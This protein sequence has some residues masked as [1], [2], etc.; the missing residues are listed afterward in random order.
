MFP[1]YSS[2]Q[3][4]KHRFSSAY[5]KVAAIIALITFPMMMGVW[6]LANP[7]ITVVFGA[8]WQPVVLLLMILAPVGMIQS[9][10]ATV[11]AIYTAKGRTDWMFRWGIGAGIFVMIAFVVGLRWGIVGVASAYAIASLILFYPSIAIPFRLIDLEFANLLKALW[12]PFTN[13]MVMF[14]VLLMFRAILPS[15]LSSGVVLTLTVAL[16]IGVYMVTNWITNR[17]QIVELWSLIRL[18]KVK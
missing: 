12:R 18:E 1:V 6:A 13:S 11:G 5:L 3:E 8:K 15:G 9:V 7:F 2:I 14:V 16:G 4:D 10:G 17:E